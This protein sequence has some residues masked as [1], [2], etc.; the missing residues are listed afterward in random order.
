M[1]LTMFLYGVGKMELVKAKRLIGGKYGRYYKT[2][3][4][5]CVKPNSNEWVQMVSIS[6]DIGV[7]TM[8]Q[9]LA[10]LHEMWIHY[11]FTA[12]G[13]YNDDCPIAIPT[14]KEFSKMLKCYYDCYCDGGASQLC[15][16]VC[17]CDGCK[18]CDA[19]PCGKGFLCVSVTDFHCCKCGH[20][21]WNV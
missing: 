1:S 13:W 15:S 21:I 18:C 11:T 16:R 9:L 2:E 14:K 3:K 20:E 6:E 5:E 12:P 4:P 8:I 19:C 7:T 10:K 17:G